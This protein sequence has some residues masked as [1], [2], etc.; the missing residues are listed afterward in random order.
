MTYHQFL[1]KSYLRPIKGYPGYSLTNTGR[2]YSHKS[3]RYLKRQK[4]GIS[5]ITINGKI[6]Q[7]N[8]LKLL[9]KTYPDVEFSTEQLRNYTNKKIRQR[10]A[11]HFP[12]GLKKWRSVISSENTKITLGYFKTKKEALDKFKKS[13][14]I[15]RGYKPW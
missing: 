14:L 15:L 12:I 10:G 9:L 4:N 1:T 5:Y 8:P 2:I 7:L 3:D 13:Y 11:Y 6:L